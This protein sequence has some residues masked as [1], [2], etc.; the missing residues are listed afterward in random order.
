M[1]VKIEPFY[2][3]KA[4]LHYL[5]IIKRIEL[6]TSMKFPAVDHSRDKYVSHRA[7][8]Q[9]LNVDIPNGNHS[10]KIPNGNYSAKIPNGNHSAKIPNGNYSAK[11]R[12]KIM[13]ELRHRRFPML[14][15][16][17]P[18]VIRMVS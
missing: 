11:I 12:Q 14:G 15:V 1:D 3:I 17:S 9:K 4:L 7:H 5:Y 6:K 8:T 13:L 16:R 2:L 10:A 18:M